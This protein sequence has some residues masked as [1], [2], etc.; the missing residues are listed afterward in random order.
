[1]KREAQERKGHWKGK[2]NVGLMKGSSVHS[3]RG[4]L[5]SEACSGEEELERVREW[6]ES[7]MLVSE[8]LNGTWQP[9]LE[10]ECLVPT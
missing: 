5:V 7:L 1:M 3:E 4:Q 8:K 6:E 10:F 2:G 9:K